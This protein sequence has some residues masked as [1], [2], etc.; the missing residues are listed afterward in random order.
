MAMS[1]WIYGV[2]SVTAA[3]RSG[4]RP[5]FDS[6]WVQASSPAATAAVAALARARGVPVETRDL[7]AMN[8]AARDR[9]HQ[10]VLL[11]AA[12]RTTTPVVALGNVETDSGGRSGRRV[13]GATTKRGRA[14]G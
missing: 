3:L 5:R 12:P 6:L 11:S 8:R 9:P 7:W 14:E 4:L 10:G 2:S 13:G 1:E